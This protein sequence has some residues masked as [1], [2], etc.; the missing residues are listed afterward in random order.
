MPVKLHPGMLHVPS[1]NLGF[2]Q[3]YYR[4]PVNRRVSSW[5]M[6]GDAKFRFLTTREKSFTYVLLKAPNVDDTSLKFY[7]DLLRAHITR[8]GFSA[9]QAQNAKPDNDLLVS[10][11]A[12][13]ERVL[14][15]AQTKQ[16]NFVI[17]VLPEADRSW[18]CTFKNLCDRKFGLHSLCIVE[19][20]KK[21]ESAFKRYMQNV[22]MKINL[23]FGGVNHTALTPT[24]RLTDTMFLGADL[25]H[26]VSGTIAAVVG[27]VDPA[28]GRCL[29]SVRLQDVQQSDHEVCVEKMP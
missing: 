15:I 6:P 8:C 11:L 24:E 25:V 22:S 1:L 7:D 9:H 27:S 23:K 18:Y 17:L 14:E 3:V 16:V 12:N 26:T 21:G 29:G 5:P 2:P 10:S 28:V 13:M 19:N 4:Q 20:F